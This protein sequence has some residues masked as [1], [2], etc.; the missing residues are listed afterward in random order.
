M[1]VGVDPTLYSKRQWDSM[2]MELTA[3]QKTLEA[4]SDNLID[5]V[6]L[7]RQPLCGKDNVFNL[8]NEFS[9]RSTTE[10][11][12]KVRSEMKDNGASVLVVTELDEVACTVHLQETRRLIRLY[13]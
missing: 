12:S 8:G 9:G 10:K 4:I 2:S 7:G 1:R 5:V 13:C 11:L 6:W 3:A